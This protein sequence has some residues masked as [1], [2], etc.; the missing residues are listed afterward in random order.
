MVNSN[1]DS[2]EF[3][4][5]DVHNNCEISE[6][7]LRRMYEFVCR[8]YTGHELDTYFGNVSRSAFQSCPTRQPLQHLHMLR[9]YLQYKRLTQYKVRFWHLRLSIY[10][11]VPQTKDTSY[12]ISSCFVRIHLYIQY[13]GKVAIEPC[14]KYT[15]IYCFAV[16]TVPDTFQSVSHLCRL[17][18]TLAG[19]ISKLQV[20]AY[21]QNTQTELLTIKFSF[22]YYSPR[23]SMHLSP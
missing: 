6:I 9:E 3:I 22:Q 7:P 8:K 15:C 18:V 23:Y 13:F 2:D 11:T 10:F 21:L 4:N 20:S 5:K 1:R 17:S 12:A 14:P 19:I 16:A